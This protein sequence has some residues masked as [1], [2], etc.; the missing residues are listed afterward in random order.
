MSRADRVREARQLRAE[1]LLLREIAERFGIAVSTASDWINDP[2]GSRLRARK[3]SYA[4][5]CAECGGPTDGSEGPGRAP[6]RCMECIRWTDDEIVEAMRRWA[7]DYDRPPKTWDWRTKG[8]DHP[9]AVVVT[10]RMGWNVALRMA[11]LPVAR[12]LQRPARILARLAEGASVE[13]AALAQNTTVDNVRE[14][15]RRRGLS[16]ADARNG[17]TP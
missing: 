14:V 7:A 10:R 5:T 13:E 6:R 1:G 12:D 11:G 16:L 2:D 3:A 4:G 17:R 8:V 15:L 9:T